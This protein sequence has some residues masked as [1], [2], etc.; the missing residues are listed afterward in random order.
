MVSLLTRN[1]WTFAVR[2]LMTVLF[3]VAAFVWPQITW[4]AL[5]VVLG[6]YVLRDGVLALASALAS[7]FV[8][9]GR[10][11]LILEG[12]AGMIVGIVTLLY[13][14]TSS[15][16]LVYL[17]A[18]WAIAT[19]IVEMALAI[20][21]RDKIG[22]AGWFVLAGILSIVVGVLLAWQPGAGAVALAWFIGTC[23]IVFGIVQFVIA[24]RL[25]ELNNRITKRFGEAV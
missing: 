8:F 15:V 13:V 20:D 23:A 16:V 14:H 19:G 11:L 12:I 4:Q 3:G 10:G 9:G 21:L 17:V 22:H 18:A 25:H 24:Y 6:A 5:V 2:G 1:W 7:P